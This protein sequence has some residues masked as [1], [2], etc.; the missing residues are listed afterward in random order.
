MFFPAGSNQQ[1]CPLRWH[2]RP[3]QRNTLYTSCQA[4]GCPEERSASIRASRLPSNLV[5]VDIG[6]HLSVREG[7]GLLSST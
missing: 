1:N 4:A 2:G 6:P 5:V 3:G 7:D